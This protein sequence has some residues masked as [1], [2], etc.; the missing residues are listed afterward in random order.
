MECGG[1]AVVERGNVLDKEKSDG[2][3]APVNP[4]IPVNTKTGI[5]GVPVLQP[6]DI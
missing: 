5:T 4:G 3:Q 1:N 2:Q 6:K